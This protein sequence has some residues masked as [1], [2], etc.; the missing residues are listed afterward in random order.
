M[1]EI[2]RRGKKP[3]DLK[4]DAKCQSCGTVVRFTEGEATVKG[5]QREGYAWVVKCPVCEKEIWAQ[6]VKG[7][8]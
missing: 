1:V 7:I 2:I 5:E 3:C 8:A 6:I 4:H